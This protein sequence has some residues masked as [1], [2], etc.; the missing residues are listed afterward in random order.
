MIKRIS[1]SDWLILLGVVLL[2]ILAFTWG[3]LNFSETKIPEQTIVAAELISPPVPK[4]APSTPPPPTPKKPPDPPAKVLSVAPV[5]KD[6]SSTKSTEKSQTTPS[7]KVKTQDPKESDSS[8]SQNE[9][10]APTANTSS[11]ASDSSNN[12]GV[13]G[14]VV[15]IYQLQMVYRPNTEV[16]YPSRSKDI[17]EQGVV[18]IILNIN[19]QGEVSSTRVARSSGFARLDQAA[20]DL[21][22]HI[23]FKPYAPN[24][25][26][27]K[28]SASIAIRFQL[29]H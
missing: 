3:L 20:S 8:S 11:S 26:P 4:T 21:A 27:V 25:T 13:E 17:G 24:G 14:G 28:V 7:E 2:H 18:G 5:K 22:G 19:E 29:S 16:F 10:K 12:L 6:P 1:K 9:A 23:R 15:Q